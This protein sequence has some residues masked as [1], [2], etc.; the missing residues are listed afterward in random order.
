MRRLFFL[1]LLLVP[2]TVFGQAKFQVHVLNQS[3]GYTMNASDTVWN[4]LEFDIYLQ[5]DSSSSPAW[6][7]LAGATLVITYNSAL[8]PLSPT[9][10]PFYTFT[11]GTSQ[12]TGSQLTAATTQSR[13]SV[14]GVQLR[15]S[16]G[17]PPGAGN[18]TIIST[19]WPGTRMIRAKMQLWTGTG[20]T[21][22]PVQ[23]LNGTPNLAWRVPPIASPY[24]NMQAYIGGVNTNLTLNVADVPG[25]R[26]LPAEL[27]SFSARL[28]NNTVDLR[29]R[30]TTEVN[31][32][33]FDVERRI[34]T[35]GQWTSLGFVQGAGTSNTPRD[36]SFRDG[37]LPKAAD[38]YYRLKQM[39][40]DGRTEYSSTVAVK[41]GSTAAF[42]LHPNFPNPFIGSTTLAF[43]LPQDGLTSIRVYDLNGR[44][45]KTVAEDYMLSGYNS[46]TID[47]NGLLPGTYKYTVQNGS[48]LK[49]GSFTVT[50]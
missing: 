49:S 10:Y 1:L 20:G 6:T 50:K 21:G 43:N 46:L 7:E 11:P 35:D 27:T 36:Y 16:N 14:S 37:N 40:R 30:T 26:L 31:N 29:W 45:V 4:S 48:A 13:Y 3:I 25:N 22:T 12:L 47:A 18:G 41:L 33:G 9:T 28:V 34:G 15:W 38:L 32:H 8:V 19:T 5:A 24:T 2:L 23:F 17:T 42:E 44:L 39:D